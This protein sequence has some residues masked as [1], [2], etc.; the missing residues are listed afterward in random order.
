M[1]TDEIPGS[2]DVRLFEYGRGM[3]YRIRQEFGAMRDALMSVLIERDG[4]LCREC[5]T[6]ENMTIDHVVPV[7]KGGKNVIS[8]LQLLCRTCNSRKGA[9]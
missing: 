9:R 5:G 6:T 2:Y 3:A 4:Y 8:N 7:V 1:K